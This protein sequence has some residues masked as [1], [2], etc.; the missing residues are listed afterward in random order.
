MLINAII[1]LLNLSLIVLE[2]FLCHFLE[3]HE[4]SLTFLMLFLQHANLP[5][6]LAALSTG[7]HH[8]ITTADAYR[9]AEIRQIASKFACRTNILLTLLAIVDNDISVGRGWAL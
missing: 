5:V 7:N 2:F 8:F 1:P 6:S 9:A 3:I 4:I